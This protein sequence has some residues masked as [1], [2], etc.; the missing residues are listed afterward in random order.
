MSREL[1][2]PAGLEHTTLDPEQAATWDRADGHQPFFGRLVV[3][4]IPAI[5][6]A[7]G[8]GWVMSCA[9]DMA[10]WLI[11]Q[12]DAGQYNGNQL[13]PSDDVKESQTP[14]TFF[15]ENGSDLAY[16]MGWFSGESK[17]GTALVWHGGD[18]PNFMSDMLLV[19]E[20]NFGVMVLANAQSSSLGH[21][22]GP[23]IASIIAGLNLE[24]SAVPWW[25]Y[26]KT[27]DTM[28]LSVSLAVG[29]VLFVG[30]LAWEFRKRNRYVVLSPWA[31]PS[32]PVYVFLLYMTP[33]MLAALVFSVGYTIVQTLFGYNP[34][35]AMAEFRLV[36]PPGAWI[37]SV[38]FFGVT[39]TWGLVL[40]FSALFTGTRTT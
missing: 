34:F 4:N 36:S 13:I 22:L 23:G 12:L 7:R 1:F 21:S 24:R 14:E 19:P 37:A 25:A 40:A 28:A 6:S 27:I 2:T 39:I 35:D 9:E 18:T 30:R 5:K 33:L 26:W 16:G 3:R 15:R 31:K 10:H 11:L 17:D 29:V 20:N 8:A 32:L 38:T